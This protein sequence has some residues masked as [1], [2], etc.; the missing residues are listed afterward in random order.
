MTPTPTQ[1][2][3]LVISLARAKDRRES[4]KRHLDSMRIQ[5][6]FVE[7]TDGSMLPEDEIVRLVAPG[8]SLHPGTVGCYL[9][10]LEAYRRIVADSLPVALV[11]E[12]DAR[13]DR[14]VAR[15]LSE[16]LYCTDFDYCFLDCDD[17]NDR[18]PVFY[19]ADSGVSIGLGFR[20]YTLSDGPQTLHA[21]LITRAAAKQRLD[22]AY[23]IVKAIDLYDHLSY[24]I[25]FRAIVGTKAAWVSQHS[26]ESS[27]SSK[28]VS[29]GT[30]RFAFLRRWPLFYSLKRWASL[31]PIKDLAAVRAARRNGKLPPG[32]R[33]RMLPSGREI[34]IT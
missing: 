16:G 28:H 12:D 14:R 30:L 17:H 10:H 33:W 15:L 24:S 11:L 31:Q 3:V 27:T 9:S 26:L 34:L 1:I 13:L 22:H 21:Y 2:P 32:R 29:I 18:G 8:V 19:D 5:H 4:I 25:H 20:A 23:P 6:S 7:G